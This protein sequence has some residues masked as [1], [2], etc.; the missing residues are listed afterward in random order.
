MTHILPVSS[1]TTAR[2][3]ARRARVFASPPPRLRTFV[4][5]FS[6]VSL[7]A[8]AAL[9]TPFAF[10]PTP[11]VAVAQ[12]TLVDYDT[13]D[14]NLIEVST[15]AQWAAI[16]HDVDTDGVPTNAGETA[17]QTAFP[18][19]MSGNG[20][21]STCNGYELA[22]HLNFSGQTFTPIGSSTVGQ[23]F[24]GTFEGNGFQ[25]QNATLNSGTN[26]GVFLRTETTATIRGL[27]VIEPNFSNSATS[28]VAGIVAV[29]N[30][31]LIGSYVIG[32]RNLSGFTTGG[33][34]G[35]AYAD[36]TIA[37]SYARV[38]LAAGTRPGQLNLGGIIGYA[39]TMPTCISS[40]FHGN[41]SGTPNLGPIGG[42][43]VVFGGQ[44]GQGV[45]NTGCTG[46]GNVRGT[47]TGSIANMRAALSYSNPASNNPFSTWNQT[48]EDGN[49]ASVDYWD[50]VD[51]YNTP[52]LKAFGHQRD[53][54]AFDYDLDDD[55][56]IDVRTAAQWIAMGADRDGNGFPETNHG[57][58]GG[59]FQAA[60]YSMGCQ[61]TDH[62]NDPDTP[63]QPTCKGY[64]LLN[65]IDFQNVTYYGVPTTTSSG[66]SLNN[67]QPSFTG[68]VKGNGYRVVNIDY[69][70]TSRHSNGR[71]VG[72]F[73]QIANRLEGLGVWNPY[74]YTSKN[75][76]GVVA[77]SVS[78]KIIGTYVYK[79][80]RIIQDADQSGG[81]VGEVHGGG[82]VENS[83]VRGQVGAQEGKQY[84]GLIGFMQSASTCKNSY[85]S[86]NFGVR[87]NLANLIA[88][89][90]AVPPGLGFTYSN[91]YGDTTT[92]P[93][94]HSRGTGGGQTFATM[95]ST[96]DYTGIY[97]PW[98]TDEDGDGEN[99]DVWDFGGPDELPV[100][101]GYGHDR[102][103]PVQPVVGAWLI[104]N[105][106][107]ICDRTLAVANEII[108]H[109]KDDVWRPGLS[110]TEVPQSLQNLTECTSREDTQNV[111]IG[112][113]NDYVVT[114]PDNPFRLNPERTT[115]PSPQLTELHHRDFEYLIR[116][117]H[118][119]LSGNALTTIP[120]YLFQW[121]KIHQLDLSDNA[122]TSL[123]L[124]AFS[125]QSA[126]AV[127]S[128]T[129]PFAYYDTWVDLS[130][131]RLTTE[132]L[133]YRVFDELSHITGLSLND[134][135]IS[136]VKTRWF[137]NLTNLGR[138]DAD[139]TSLPRIMGL[140]LAG[141]EVT[142]HYYY[143]KAFPANMRMN[144]ETYSGPDA[145]DI[146][147]D[148][149]VARIKAPNGL[150]P[151]DLANSDN[152]DLETIE[153]LRNG[154]IS[155]GACPDDITSGPPGSVDVNDMPVQCEEA[156]RWTPPWQEDVAPGVS[157]PTTSTTGD[158]GHIVLTFPHQRPAAG[159]LPATGYQV[160]YR[161]L[162]DDLSDP[163]MEP[164]RTVP[165]D[166]SSYG[167]KT[168]TI[169]VLMPLNVY[170]FQMRAIYAGSPSPAVSFAQGTW[171]EGIEGATAQQPLAEPGRRSIRVTFT[172]QPYMHEDEA[173]EA[174]LAIT[175]YQMRYRPVTSDP[176]APWTRDW[177]D[178]EVDL[179]T[180]G[181]K[182][183]IVE[184]LLEGV[185]YEFQ[186][187]PISGGPVE[188]V[189]ITQ[190]TVLSLPKANAIRPVIREISV[191]AGQEVRLEVEVI[192]LQ[193]TLKN[194]LADDA[195]S[196]M[197]FRWTES[198]S[199]GGTFATPSTD[200]RVIYTAPDLPGTYTILAEAQPDGICRDH[201]KTKL[202]ISDEDRA[203]CIATI[204]VRVS[205]AP[206]AVEPEADPVNPAGIIPTS[207]TDSAGVA[208]AVFTPVD[209]GT[210][211]GEGITV[212]AP[213]GAIPD[214]QLLGVSAARSSIPVPE[215]FPGAR[216]T[217]AAPYYEINGV[218]RTGDAPV[219]G[220]AL[221][222]PIR[223]CMPIPAMF[224][225]DISSVAV[226]NRAA[227]DGSITILTSSIRQTESGLA[228]CGNIGQLPATVAVANVGIIEATPEPPAPGPEDLP[229][230]G[231]TTPGIWSSAGT[232]AWAMVAAVWVLSVAT[233]AAIISTRRRRHAGTIPKHDT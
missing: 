17:W 111:R 21:A 121:E 153:N 6:V 158:D 210:F 100:L 192:S 205:R 106:V 214:Q 83:F 9:G 190:T 183:V 209:G 216:L 144:E 96:D 114:T 125:G 197:I 104:W 219:S 11:R 191:R 180:A 161:P 93:G 58:H 115:P 45:D 203:P 124:E 31:K 92:A 18:N 63:D 228:A 174:A 12:T 48:D 163:W 102:T 46:A 186:I 49:T 79:Y 179:S 118:F 84:G 127:E 81:L 70:Q 98:N 77:G 42:A 134:N 143:N 201:H 198:P 166:L 91:C 224:R 19:A 2:R 55:G 150:R 50:F 33:L 67:G 15:R 87:T 85:F 39:H 154:M 160:R 178:I 199:G 213:E 52:V 231:G 32:H 123:P 159:E 43:G 145:G 230:T 64:E 95:A 189:T 151:A 73:G 16:N 117:A 147:R 162:P 30:G 10:D 196:L 212:T 4:L 60:M 103:F 156:T 34:V 122:L 76:G 86:G 56:L 23:G 113:L 157:A 27:G 167:R 164:W 71:G 28:T 72:V 171:P 131:N 112:E 61:L 195:D 105:S 110:V 24:A 37:H 116:A 80:G 69:P 229:E 207:L 215:P 126:S 155:K 165:V 217:I 200:R 74:V 99:D 3:S 132:G 35:F 172:H 129:V 188:S 8:L 194:D 220:Y 40:Y 139:A 204:T 206:G 26:L 208:Y 177:H 5:A 149:I 20:C 65:D 108:R 223:A 137:D 133:P 97:A 119:D 187:R 193:D 185:R 211:S 148:A 14:D 184:P 68:I 44:N 130:N 141:N 41:M 135:A 173:R 109:L 54:Q 226:V 57:G 175:G 169:T 233:I 13:D 227:S 7:L 47:V 222:D 51:A 25:I 90:H 140:H 36:S 29:H 225:A 82:V 152:L 38:N 78:G 181:P 142:G 176:N 89:S 53:R 136:E 66:T 107:N 1:R 232:T 218:Q 101:K 88:H 22:R 59:A 170:Q 221:D 62:D 120:N 146:L 75:L 182:S 202:G 128:A 94:V 168:V 138:R